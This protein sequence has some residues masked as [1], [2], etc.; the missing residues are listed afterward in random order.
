MEQ[1]LKAELA[2]PDLITLTPKAVEKV[3]EF[4]AQEPKEGLALRVTVLPGG[5]AGFTYGLEFDENV[6]E[7]DFAIPYDGFHVVVDKYSAALVKGSSIDY[8]ESLEA[9]HFSFNNPNARSGCGCG[10]SF[11]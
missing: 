1:T 3:R 11:S 6:G 5:C 8:V 7:E 4:M 9:S 2:K 10:K